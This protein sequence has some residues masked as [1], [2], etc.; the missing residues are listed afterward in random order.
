MTFRLA[1][2][3]RSSFPAAGVP[4]SGLAAGWPN[5]GG[6]PSEGR[7][8]SPRELTAPWSGPPT[9]FVLRIAL[10]APAPISPVRAGDTQ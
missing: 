7:K 6:F 10:L 8:C 3:R 2:A 5:M 9:L 1:R 4:L